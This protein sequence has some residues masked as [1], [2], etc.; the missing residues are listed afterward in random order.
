MTWEVCARI[1]LTHVM[2]AMQTARS[3]GLRTVLAA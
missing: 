3:G 2:E 1:F